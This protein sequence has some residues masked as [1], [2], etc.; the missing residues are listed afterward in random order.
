MSDGT[1]R[2]YTVDEM[3]IESRRVDKLS[4]YMDLFGDQYNLDRIARLPSQEIKIGKVRV[5][6]QPLPSDGDNW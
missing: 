2:N 4:E 6:Q 1:L 3:S 5:T